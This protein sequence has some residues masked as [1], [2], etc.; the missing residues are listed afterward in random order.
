MNTTGPRVPPVAAPAHAGA[1]SGQAQAG[2]AVRRAT[3]MAA[4]LLA[5]AGCATLFG[6]AAPPKVGARPPPWVAWPEAEVAT[7]KDAHAYRGQPLC[8]R[9]H[10]GKDGAL[11]T[12]PI[13]L[14]KGCH[15][16]RHGNH[17]VGVV[18]KPPAKDLP[19]GAGDVIVCHTCHDPH[20][21]KSR[22]KGLR[23]AFNDLCLRCHQ[24]H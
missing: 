5:T 7:A 4:L 1:S 6:A 21:L 8:Q 23:L 22:R 17:P 19:Y 11:Q 16:Q 9:C 3:T 12:E 13:A 15:P 24:Q 14:C 18:H 20:D 2:A 10:T